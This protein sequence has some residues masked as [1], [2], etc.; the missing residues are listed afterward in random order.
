M[1]IKG[2][3]DYF[4]LAGQTETIYIIQLVWKTSIYPSILDYFQ[5]FSIYWIT[6]GLP[7]RTSGKILTCLGKH[8][9]PKYKTWFKY[10]FLE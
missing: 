2:S 3:I 5:L 4:R 7:Q 1:L 9:T 10:F 8:A 6:S